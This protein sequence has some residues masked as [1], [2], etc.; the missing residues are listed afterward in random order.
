MC[1]V[2]LEAAHED[3]RNIVAYIS[4]ENPNAAE[5]LGRELLDGAVSLRSLPYRG[6]RAKKRRGLLKLIRGSYLIYYRINEQKQV[7]QIVDFASV[8]RALSAGLKPTIHYGAGR[9]VA[10]HVDGC[11]A[12]VRDAIHA[13]DQS[14][15]GRWHA[16][17]PK[18]GRQHDYAHARR[19]GRPNRGANRSARKCDQARDVKMYPKYLSQKWRSRANGL[20]CSVMSYID[21]ITI[22]PG[23]CGGRPCIRGYRL[24]VKDVLE[25]LAH[26]ASWDEILEDYSFLEREDIQACL[27]FAAAQSDHALIKVS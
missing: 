18:D 17:S 1:V 21:R 8:L 13:N 4:N 27:D 5:F 23:K 26:G 25:L 2:I 11:S 19:A 3:L 15:A 24:R 12:H 16:D 7:V 14:N 10:R 20:K 22:E 9:Q 6:S